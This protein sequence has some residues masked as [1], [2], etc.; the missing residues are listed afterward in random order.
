MI[1]AQAAG[2]I[3]AGLKVLTRPW[4]FRRIASAASPVRTSAI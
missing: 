2:A 4:P 3:L 1:E